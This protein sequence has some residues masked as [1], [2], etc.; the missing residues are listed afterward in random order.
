[1]RKIIQ[2]GY[3]FSGHIAFI[4]IVSLLLIPVYYLGFSNSY[5]M[6]FGCVIVIVSLPIL[7]LFK[8][9]MILLMSWVGVYGFLIT[10]VKPIF[11]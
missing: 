8:M 4:G 11:L 5:F 6:L 7:N 10:V 9:V 2:M 1:M 3:F